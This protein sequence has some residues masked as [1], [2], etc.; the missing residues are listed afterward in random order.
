[1]GEK[2]VKPGLERGNSDVQTA[3]SAPASREDTVRD[4][5]GEWPR[6]LCEGRAI[7]GDRRDA[8][9]NLR[10]QHRPTAD[11]L[12]PFLERP[13]AGRCQARVATDKSRHVLHGRKT[14]AGSH[15][16]QW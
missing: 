9:R 6:R 11:L 1:M 7:A 5:F 10:R 15:C 13:E 16:F 2:M 8:G 3:P 14:G 12:T 4:R